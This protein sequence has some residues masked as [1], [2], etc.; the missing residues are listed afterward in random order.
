MKVENF[1]YGSAAFVEYTLREGAENV[2]QEQLKAVGD[3]LYECADYEGH[4]A[5]YCANEKK[6]KLVVPLNDQKEGIF[7]VGIAIGSFAQAM[8]RERCI[9][10]FSTE[11][12][13]QAFEPELEYCDMTNR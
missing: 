2:T 6:I 10:S 1:G 9:D 13:M 12:G 4:F 5:L 7:E 11:F 8:K 3:L